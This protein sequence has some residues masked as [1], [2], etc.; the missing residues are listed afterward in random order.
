M[1]HNQLQYLPSAIGRAT[2]LMHL[3]VAQ[4]QIT[5]IPN[6][7]QK[8]VNLT[9]LDVTNN[10]LASLPRIHVIAAD[11]FCLFAT[12]NHVA[13]RPAMYLGMDS[14]KFRC[15]V[16]ATAFA[17]SATINHICQGH[18]TEV[19][20]AHTQTSTF[21]N[22]ITDIIR[23]RVPSTVSLLEQCFRFVVKAVVAG[24]HQLGHVA[25]EVLPPNL[26]RSLSD[27]S[28]CDECS[29]VFVSEYVEIIVG[30]FGE[31]PVQWVCCSVACASRVATK[32]T[33]L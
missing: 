7:I 14:F 22:D 4:N 29:S 23:D 25:S 17:E 31:L 26:T 16:D 24:N 11:K 28:R 6:S 19:H 18:V 21:P 3:N 20:N 2:A 33:E 30:V 15:S 1:S 10:R 8:C 13:Y 32:H 12:G 9:R 5:E 27:Q